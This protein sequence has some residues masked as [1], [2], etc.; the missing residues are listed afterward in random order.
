[1]ENMISCY[2]YFPP[3]EEKLRWRMDGAKEL[4]YIPAYL[5]DSTRSKKIFHE[6]KNTQRDMAR[7]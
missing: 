3:Q 2:R 7:M 4:S 6:E 1:M 5:S